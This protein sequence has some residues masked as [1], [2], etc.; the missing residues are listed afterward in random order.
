VSA[1]GGA[2][3]AAVH[4]WFVEHND[5]ERCAGHEFHPLSADCVQIADRIVSTL[6]WPDVDR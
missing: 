2:I 3:A 5:D 6:D 1:L 4:Q